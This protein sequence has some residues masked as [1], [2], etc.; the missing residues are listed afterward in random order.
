M[1]LREQREDTKMSCFCP[2]MLSIDNNNFLKRENWGP[3]RFIKLL[4]ITDLITSK[5]SIWIQ[6]Y[7]SLNLASCY[8]N[9]LHL[10]FSLYYSQ[11]IMAFFSSLSFI[12]ILFIPQDSAP[13]SMKLY[14]WFQCLLIKLFSKLPVWASFTEGLLCVRYTDI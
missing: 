14:W 5:V 7:L 11:D 4:K 10:F 9:L 6:D 8:E 12:Q 3:E 2:R 1:K 13:I